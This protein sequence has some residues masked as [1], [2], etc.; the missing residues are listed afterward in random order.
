MEKFIEI[1]S[2]IESVSKQLTGWM[3]SVESKE[4]L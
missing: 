2:M 3:R 4:S 1:N